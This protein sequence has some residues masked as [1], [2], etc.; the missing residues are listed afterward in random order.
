[1]LVEQRGDP[2]RYPPSPTLC[3]KRV[4]RLKSDVIITIVILL[5]AKTPTSLTLTSTL[6]AKLTYPT[7]QGGQGVGTTPIIPITH[8]FLLS[9]TM[10]TLLSL[11]R[12]SDP[13]KAS[14]LSTQDS[15][16]MSLLPFHLLDMNP[17]GTC[18]LGA[19]ILPSMVPR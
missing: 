19:W 14:Q 7:F 10:S 15:L 2:T 8:I 17:P 13:R 3:L 1:M 11:H 5:K 16:T 18:C 12:S 6:Q 4:L 9:T